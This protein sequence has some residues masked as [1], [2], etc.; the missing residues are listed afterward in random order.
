[1][2]ATPISVPVSVIWTVR[3]T[4]QSAEA[5][6]ATPLQV[7]VAQVHIGLKGAQGLQG[8][9]GLQGYK[10]D[11]GDKGDTGDVTPAAE[12][13]LEAA[14]EARND[15]LTH[16][17]TAGTQA[18]VAT[19]KA[20]EAAA[21]VVLAET[22]R[23]AAFVNAD[24]YADVATGLA[25]VAD[26]VQFQV[27]SADGLSI[28]RYRRDAG[29][30]AVAVGP[31]YPS[32]E[33][34]RRLAGQGDF[35]WKWVMV[36]GLGRI[37]IGVNDLGETVV[38]AVK[39]T[40]GADL[41]ALAADVVRVAG[42]GDF[43]L[44]Y[45]IADSEGRTAFGIDSVGRT[46][47]K[48]ALT[49][50]GVSLAATALIAAQALADA[51][52][53]GASQ[54]RRA[55]VAARSQWGFFP[56]PQMDDAPTLTLVQSGATPAGTTLFSWSATGLWRTTGGFT[57][58]FGGNPY[59]QWKSKSPNGNA[60]GFTAAGGVALETVHT[61]TVL[62]VKLRGAGGQVRVLVGDANGRRMGYVSKTAVAP[63]P[64]GAQWILTIDFG[65][66]SATRTILI[67]GDGALQFGGL[68]VAAGE[69]IAAPS[70]TKPLVCC[71]G[72]S[73]TEHH[74]SWART[75]GYMLG[76]DV[77][78]VGVGSSGVLNPGTSPRVKQMDRSNDLT[79]GNFLLG[80]DENGIND[81]GDALYS[82]ATYNAVVR[83]FG[84]EYRRILDA[85]FTA[86]P[87]SPFI[88]WGPYWPN[89]GPVA[90]A[91]RIRDAKQRVISEYP[92]A[93]FIDTLTPGNLIQGNVTSGTYPAADFLD[94]GDTTHP[95]EPG[96]EFIGL[97]IFDQADRLIRTVF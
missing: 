50:D 57:S 25:A 80:V 66:V 53:G 30:V 21:S 44:E 92:L 32:G 81:T 2:S 40:G 79:V 87:N 85:W 27:V 93:A 47:V 33:V 73:I 24:V 35:V 9:Q 19:T 69:S 65:V 68:W 58:Q 3:S 78:N 59:L 1:M 49:F 45:A 71:I 86:H 91:Y 55:M 60:G 13:A 36:D 29:P 61:G 90:N 7:S 83:E 8:L 75:F 48:D 95:I 34:V 43:S 10:G 70:G 16:A 51:Q 15:A 23:D 96:A 20:G 52:S 84:D 88:G 89:E 4:G 63:N 18:G 56:R 94:P 77:Y 14:V 28:Q 6:P 17:G 37:A 62:H 54:F 67:E 41:D 74:N 26:G 31:G 12:A 46:R 39:T 64:D 76:A 5:T 97:H 42:E 72:T 82:A 11:K 22:A 38:K